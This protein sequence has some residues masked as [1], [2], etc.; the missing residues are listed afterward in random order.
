MMYGTMSE[1]AW[2]DYIK[3][4]KYRESFEI[5]NVPI[6]TQSSYVRNI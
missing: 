2:R 6:E 1:F 4:Q 5:V 3:P